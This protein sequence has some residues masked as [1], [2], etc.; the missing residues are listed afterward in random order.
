G[1]GSL[2]FFVPYQQIRLVAAAPTRGA[3]VRFH[4]NFL[5]VE[6]FHAEVGCSGIL[7]N[8]PAGVPV[9]TLPEESWCEVRR[10][11]DRL[12]REQQE[13]ELAF[14]ELMLSD[15]KVLLT[16]ATRI[17]SDAADA[18]GAQGQSRAGGGDPR[19]PVLMELRELIEQ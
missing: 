5:C 19:H 8:D 14:S 12:R 1:A 3:V 11:V 2:L 10:L 15:L 6:T 16:L 18:A 4:A 9:V 17:K 13:Q 7:F